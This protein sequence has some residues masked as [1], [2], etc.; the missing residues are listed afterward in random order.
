MKNNAA[1]SPIRDAVLRLIVKS[2][3]KIGRISLKVRNLS[4]ILITAPAK[5]PKI[6]KTAT[7]SRGAFTLR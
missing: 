5:I 2:A 6:R 3:I 7:Q 1:E 4:G